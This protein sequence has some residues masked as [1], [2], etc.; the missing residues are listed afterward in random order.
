MIPFRNSWPY[1]ITGNDVIVQEC[2]FCKS[3]NVILPLKPADVES[4]YGGARKIMLVFPCCHNRLR[5]I[6]AD[7]D[8]LLANRQIR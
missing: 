8:Y 1:D 2:P 7:S 5:I 3:A 6:D 4:L